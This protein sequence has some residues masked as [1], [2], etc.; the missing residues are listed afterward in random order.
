MPGFGERPP[1]TYQR[2]GIPSPRLAHVKADTSVSDIAFDRNMYLTEPI[3]IEE[4]SK[5]LTSEA[6]HDCH[7]MS[8]RMVNYTSHLFHLKKCKENED[9]K[10]RL[11]QKDRDHNKNT[12]VDDAY[13]FDSNTSNFMTMIEQCQIEMKQ[14]PIF[15]LT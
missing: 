12:A 6:Y 4:G 8:H 7:L 14:P 15:L 11:L 10:R 9:L 2:Q 5:I 3:E 13:V 1:M